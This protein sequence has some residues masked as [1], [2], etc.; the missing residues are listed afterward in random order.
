M[1]KAMCRT[2]IT[3][4]KIQRA[5]LCAEL[6]IMHSTE[7]FNLLISKHHLEPNGY[8][9]NQYTRQWEQL[10]SFALPKIHFLLSALIVRRSKLLIVGSSWPILPGFG[11]DEVLPSS[12]VDWWSLWLVDGRLLVVVV[13]TR[14]LLRFGSLGSPEPRLL[15]RRAF[16]DVLPFRDDEC[17]LLSES[18]AWNTWWKM[19]CSELFSHQ[20]GIV[21]KF[22]ALNMTKDRR[23]KNFNYFNHSHYLT[24]RATSIFLRHQ[25]KIY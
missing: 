14:W 7:S 18:T 22:M 6:S 11:N 21:N 13:G 20:H 5:P 3:C 10:R 16:L 9:V 24:T 17:L 25:N 19:L 1:T 15:D 4:A 23:T 12:P 8:S 2:E